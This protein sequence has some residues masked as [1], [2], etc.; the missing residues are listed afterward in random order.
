MLK[1]LFGFHGRMRRAVWWAIRVPT[2]V[3]LM[4]GYGLERELIAPGG[5]DGA[6][7]AGLLALF[8]TAIVVIW[9][10]LATNVKRWHDQN[11]SGFWVLVEF[12]PYVG[13]L[14]VLVVCGILDGTPGPNRFGPSPKGVG[15]E[16]AA[17]VFS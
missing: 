10:D 7:A 15:G 13:P 1:T 17:E 3:V 2:V 5:D 6:K 12:V 14:V 4:M 16:T 8:L 11:R 9:I